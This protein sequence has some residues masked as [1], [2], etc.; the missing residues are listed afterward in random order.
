[1][2]WALCLLCLLLLAPP[3]PA[4]Q[5]TERWHAFTA[6]HG[7]AG[8]IVQALWEDP[9]GRM[10]FGTENGVSRYDGRSWAS[11]DEGD[12]LIDS[13]VWS[14][15]GSGDTVWLATSRG[16]SRLRDGAWRSY[17]MADGLPGEDV[18]AVLVASDGT[19]WAGLFGRGIARLAPGA[20]RW[21]VFP[22]AQTE[23]QGAFV[24]AIWQAPS[25]DLW[26]SVSGAGAFRLRAA[27]FER[28]TF[29]LG[30]RNT[31]WSFGT[32]PGAPD[33][34]LGTFLGLARIGA[35]DTVTLVD[36]LVQGIPLTTT[37]ILAVAGDE[38]GRSNSSRVP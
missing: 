38:R 5:A 36:D 3:T 24:Q 8:N 37:E 14:I 15:S 19:V 16:I 35:D 2:N 4:A 26:F 23:P 1:M 32:I 18:R 11:F 17:G 29:R 10:W 21:E 34:Y 7:L 25:G 31:V 22:L 13:N 30:N 20:E 33:V 9:A 12:G 28:F 6:T 27:T